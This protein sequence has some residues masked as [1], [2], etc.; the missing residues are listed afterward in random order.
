MGG[1]CSVAAALVAGAA[2]ALLLL[3]LRTRRVALA[4]CR[5]GALLRALPG[6]LFGLRALLLHRWA[7]AHAA[8]PHTA[9][10][11]HAAPRARARRAVGQAQTAFLGALLHLLVMLRAERLAL[12]H[13]L[14]AAHLVAIGVALGRGHQLRAIDGVAVLQAVAVAQAVL[15][16][17]SIALDVA[18]RRTAAALAALLIGGKGGRGQAAGEGNGR[19][20]GKQAGVAHDGISV[21]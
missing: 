9:A 11:P 12:L 14:E 4:G 18:A 19:G 13:G 5:R 20:Y 2:L 17:Q 3:G 21:T 16:V 6:L 10:R 7:W 8:R 1:G 15:V